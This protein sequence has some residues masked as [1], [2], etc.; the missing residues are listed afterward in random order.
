M[1]TK[2]QLEELF[3]AYGALKEVRLVTFKN[4]HSKGLAYVD[5]EDEAH[6]SNAL[7]AT[8]GTTLEGKVISVAFS[9]PPERKKPFEEGETSGTKSLGGSTT[10]RTTFGAPKTVLSMVPRN[11][12]VNPSNGSSANP[13]PAMNNQDFRKMLLEKKQ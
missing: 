3:Q 13:K 9:K 6:A 7:I 12:R 2:E 8:D 10:T 1:T 11:V 5:F 4:G